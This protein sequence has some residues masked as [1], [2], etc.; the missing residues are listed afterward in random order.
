M[1]DWSIY[2][3]ARKYFF[4]IQYTIIH[5][6]DQNALIQLDYRFVWSPILPK[7]IFLNRNRH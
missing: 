5:A 3:G 2:N 7:G 4:Q 6:A 1:K